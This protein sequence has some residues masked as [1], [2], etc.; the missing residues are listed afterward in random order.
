M[1]ELAQETPHVMNIVHPV[2]SSFSVRLLFNEIEAII[3]IF[4]TLCSVVSAALLPL[5]QEIFIYNTWTSR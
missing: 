2:L 4:F 5:Q 1:K 3:Y